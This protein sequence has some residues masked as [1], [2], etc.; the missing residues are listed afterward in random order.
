MI[1]LRR[2]V[3]GKFALYRFYFDCIRDRFFRNQNQ[4]S[5]SAAT[6]DFPTVSQV[7]VLL[8]RFLHFLRQHIGEHLQ[9]RLKG[10]NGIFSPAFGIL[11]EDRFP[12]F[13]SSFGKFSGTGLID[14]GIGQDFVAFSPLGQGDLPIGKLI[15][16]VPEQVETVVVELDY[17][18]KEMHTALRESYEY[19]TSNGFAEGN[20]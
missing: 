11:P 7:A 16:A 20:K 6:G 10:F 5:A 2:Q 9:L 8:D 13:G 1:L 12:A 18:C 4:I 14:I 15:E 3:A 17:C 19:M